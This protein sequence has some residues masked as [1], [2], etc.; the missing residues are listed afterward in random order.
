MLGGF[1]G[2]GK[3]TALLRVAREYA[4]AGKLVGIITNDQAEGLVD[5]ETF[6]TQ[7]FVTEEIPRGCFCCKFDELIAAAG[8]LADGHKLDVLLAEP[9][10]SC[11][12]LVATVI[13]PL[14]KLYTDRFSVAPNVALLDPH[15]AKQALGGAGGFS[16][17]VTYL[18]KMQQNE[19][20]VVAV[21]KM[22]L[23]LP[24]QRAELDHKIQARCAAL[25]L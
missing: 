3:T 16:T 10:G 24:E 13:N 20:D 23:L 12:D 21:N 6:R 17:K 5:T 4:E 8:R 11:T 9:V 7:G 14:K 2:A 1:L 15:R 25:G 18:F 22:D 19:A